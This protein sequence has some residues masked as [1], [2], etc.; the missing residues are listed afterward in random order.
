[1]AVVGIFADPIPCFTI[2]LAKPPY[3]RYL[4]VAQA[5]KPHLFLLKEFAKRL[6]AQY[7]PYKWLRKLVIGASKIFLRRV[8]DKDESEEI[9]GIAKAADVPL[10][11]LVALNNILECIT[12]NTSGTVPTLLSRGRWR[13]SDYTAPRR[14][15]HFRTF[16]C[17]VQELRDLL[18]VL[19]FVDSSSDDPSHIIAQSITY[20]GFVGSLTAVRAFLSL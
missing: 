20:A 5:F 3:E 10:C 15:L 12:G 16:E 14:L 11:F 6:L 13:E 2:D 17:A 7:I 9:R 1:M 18:V 8:Y 19:Q 4:E